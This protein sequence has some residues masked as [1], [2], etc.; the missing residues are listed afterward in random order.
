MRI[1]YRTS[2]MLSIETRLLTIIIIWPWNVLYRVKRAAA[3]SLSGLMA[4]RT[5]EQNIPLLPRRVEGQ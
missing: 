5:A 4:I 3:Q 2:Y 1:N